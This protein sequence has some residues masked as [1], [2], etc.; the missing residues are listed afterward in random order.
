MLKSFWN[1][2]NN[3]DSCFYIIC[4]A[5]SQNDDLQQSTSNIMTEQR[6]S[7]KRKQTDFNSSKIK[8]VR[9]SEECLDN[10]NAA[11]LSAEK[12]LKDASSSKSEN[13][14]LL[15]CREKLLSEIDISSD[16]SLE[17]VILYK[18]KKKSEIPMNH[19]N[20]NNMY[21]NDNSN[22]LCSTS[23]ITNVVPNS[24]SIVMPKNNL[25][26]D[27]KSITTGYENNSI[28][29]LKSTVSDSAYITIPSVSGCK[30][31]DASYCYLTS[32]QRIKCFLLEGGM[33][34][35]DNT[36][37]SYDPIEIDQ[38]INDEIIFGVHYY[39][40]KWKNWSLGF[41]TWERFGAIYKAQKHLYN[42]LLKRKKNVDS[43]KPVNGM[44]LILSRKVITKLFNLFRNESGLS[45]PALVPEDIS[46]LF[47]S[48]D[49]GPKKNQIVREKC[50]KSYLTTI[51]LGSFR[52]QQ[53][54]RLKQWEI[55]INVVT[56][57]H[58]V[59]VENNNDLEGPPNVFVYTTSYVH[60]DSI[61]IPD[62]PPISCT[63]KKNCVSSSNCCNGMAGYSTV[64]DLNKYLIVEPGYPIYEC[65]KKCKCSL[66]CNNRVVQLGSKV[67]VAIFKTRKCGWGV[68]TIQ[69]IKK[70]QF[71]AK[72]IGEIITVEESE[73]R[74]KN[75]SS[76]I[77]NMWN[78]D[79]D[80]PQNY[81]YVIDNAHYANFTY[82]INHSCN[83]N[84]NLYAVWSNCLDRNLPELALF[85]SRD[86]L[87]GEQL[88]TNYFSR[89]NSLKKSGIRCQCD[90]KNC[91]GY[92]F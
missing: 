67:N 38:I 58:I 72:Y 6:E 24:N 52:K 47:N 65:N 13:V 69:H 10:I 21:N 32:N 49:I 92:Y 74:L 71:I 1:V 28:C 35:F 80:D 39:L 73:E 76:L 2:F 40:I 59:K 60:Q 87:A 64:Y 70:G 41:N 37:D 44:H 23:S 30:Q 36:I 4:V 62:D 79:F 63:C 84:L 19:K 61:I 81:K 15:P 14:N 85:S 3:S 7:N 86:I 66:D 12:C 75:K 51:A 50:L 18:D 29:Q 31:I 42:Y 55:D 83:A 20:Y 27:K 53:L 57:G 77:D 26:L 68:K 16:N 34:E 25:R 11:L 89:S 22:N 8:I 88:T 9:C 82:F 91:K 5:D 54:Y 43:T 78:L 48:I 46:G 33:I 56:M 45:L 90:M 17:D